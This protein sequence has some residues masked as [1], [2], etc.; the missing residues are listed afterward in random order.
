MRVVSKKVL[1]YACGD[2]G[3]ARARAKTRGRNKKMKTE[4]MNELALVISM[5]AEPMKMNED[6]TADCDADDE[7]ASEFSFKNK[8]IC[9]APSHPNDLQ[10]IDRAYTADADLHLPRAD[11]FKRNDTIAAADKRLQS[12]T[13][14]TDLLQRRYWLPIE[15]NDEPILII[16]TGFQPSKR[17]SA[18]QTDVS[19]QG[20]PTNHGQSGTKSWQCVINHYNRWNSDKIDNGA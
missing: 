4:L 18:A 10:L 7:N 19:E 6:V 9:F 14:F 11:H 15:P 3:N 12:G 20:P 17:F 16:N 5:L 1:I 2:R 8:Q 13:L